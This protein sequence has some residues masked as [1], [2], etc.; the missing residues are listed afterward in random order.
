MK[1]IGHRGAAGIALENTIESINAAK[2]ADVDAIEFDIRLT[3]DKQFILSHDI[4]T[5]RIS[6][7][8]LSVHESTVKQL[9][10]I[11]LHNGE[12][13][14][15]LKQAIAAAGDTPILIEAKGDYW[16]PELASELAT[17]NAKTMTVIAINHQELARF[18]KLLPRVKTYAVLKFHS[19]ELLESF[20]FAAK[21][22]FKGVDMNF[23]LLN[24]LT[25]RLA[26]QNKLKIIVYTVNHRWI[27][28]FLQLLFPGI[29]FTSDYPKRLKFLQK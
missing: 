16:A 4:T 3:L 25:Y 28:S 7:H 17:Y 8:T 24:P 9:Q 1:V 15:T 26:R 27:A 11:T 29:V 5:K 13:M 2:A 12:S 23:W 19:T 10:A 20:R 14:P 21:S 22:G 18:R 6:N